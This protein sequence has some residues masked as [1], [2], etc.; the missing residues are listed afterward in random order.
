[1]GLA[2]T[3]PQPARP[4]R[5]T[6]RM[7]RIPPLPALQ[8]RHRAQPLEPGSVVERLDHRQE[9]VFRPRGGEAGRALPIQR[10]QRQRRH[11]LVESAPRREGGGVGGYTG[12]RWMARL[13][14]CTLPHPHPVRRGGRQIRR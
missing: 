13:A 8:P 9:T 3:P 11:L 6:A 2:C 7:A 12:R 10:V 1:M 14:L 4:P 5:S